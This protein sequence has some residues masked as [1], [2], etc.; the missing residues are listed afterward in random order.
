MGWRY[1]FQSWTGLN[2]EL[3]IP[4]LQYELKVRD[5]NFTFLKRNYITTD[6]ED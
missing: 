6:R 1:S 5:N 3:V 2:L 4:S